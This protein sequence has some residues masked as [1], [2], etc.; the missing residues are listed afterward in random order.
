MKIRLENYP[1]EIIIDSL[2]I[3]ACHGIWPLVFKKKTGDYDLE[4]ELGQ[5]IGWINLWYRDS[6]IYRYKK[7]ARGLCVCPIFHDM[8][9]LVLVDGWNKI[10]VKLEEL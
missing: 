2:F 5:A 3:R 4:I 6:V 8:F 7:D 9:G 1:G 10:R